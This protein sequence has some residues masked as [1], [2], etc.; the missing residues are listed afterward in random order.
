MGA[1]YLKF[2]KTDIGPFKLD[3]GILRLQGLAGRDDGRRGQ[4][5]QRMPTAPQEPKT[6]MT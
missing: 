3:R 4:H 1:I 2:G 5:E 6:K